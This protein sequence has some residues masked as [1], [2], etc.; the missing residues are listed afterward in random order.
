MEKRLYAAYGSNLNFGQMTIRCPTAKLVG[1]GI[2]EDY[3]LQFK[4]R[5]QGAFATIVHKEGAMVPAA[6]WELM[7]QDEQ[8]LDWYE[9]YPSHYFK[10][11]VTVQM[12]GMA[13]TTMAYIM[14]LKREFGLP[15]PQYYQTVRE[16]Y[17]DC[18]FDPEILDHA[19]MESAKAYLANSIRQSYQESLFTR[20]EKMLEEDTPDMAEEWDE[21]DPF[22]FSEGPKL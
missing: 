16:G 7:P 18:G 13:I 14:D 15:F 22:Y 9:G 19:V 11:D 21:S 4:G 10:H 17:K 1:T 3:E 6:V 5:P 2:I 20:Q 12:D 8:A